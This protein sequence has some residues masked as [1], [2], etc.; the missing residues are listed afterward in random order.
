MAA[1]VAAAA[2]ADEPVAELGLEVS[3]SEKVTW[4]VDLDADATTGRTGFRN[5]AEAKAVVTFAKG[6]SKT[7]EEG[8]GV[9]AELAVKLDGDIKFKIEGDGS[10]AWV[11]DGGKMVLDVAKLHIGDLYIGIKSGDT[12]VG[13]LNLSNALK[14]DKFGV[15]NKGPN[16]TQGLVAGYGNDLFG[17]DVDFRSLP[18]G[19]DYYTDQYAVAAQAELKDLSGFGAKAGV[20]FGFD[21]ADFGNK[22]LGVFGSA[23][24]KLSLSDT[25]YV[26]A[27][28]GVGFEKI[29]DVDGLSNGEV[30][31][32]VLYAWGDEAD[33]NGGVYYLDN[34][35][36][37]KRTPGVGVA[38]YVPLVKHTYIDI[39][40]AFYSG[41]IIEN[42][43]ASV[44]GEIIIPV[45]NAA[46]DTGF[47]VAGGVSYKLAVGDAITVTPQAGFRFAN[48]DYIQGKVSSVFFKENKDN[49]GLIDTGFAKFN[50]A[51]LN[52]KVGAEVGGLI[53]NTTLGA[54]YQSRN[55][56]QKE[57]KAGTFNVFAKIG[58]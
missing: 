47:A 4:G 10:D 27:S 18:S 45:D 29:K 37:K 13:N 24:Y 33:E 40:P 25:N 21:P 19:D 3:G 1:M 7:T 54:Y 36:A 42:L 49:S 15:S 44:L 51:L 41:D 26:K 6:G 43:T 55:L 52:V 20:S 12:E 34:D 22:Q 31:A 14:S 57:N 9:W 5:E 35:E 39:V 38:V 28:A 50:D 11:K 48:G 56:T 17:I 16:A 30:A 53:P 32:S 2:M 46:V 8:D 58:F 23:S